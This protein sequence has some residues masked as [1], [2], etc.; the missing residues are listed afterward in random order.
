[1]P[2]ITSSTTLDIGLAEDEIRARTLAWFSNTVH[3]VKVDTPGR[4][5]IDTGSEL[6]LRLWGGLLI[7][8]TS[9][10]TRT[11]VTIRRRPGEQSEV[12]ITSAT[13]TV[14]IKTG[15]KAR[16]KARFDEIVSGVAAALTST[17]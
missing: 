1:V 5:S 2:P 9:L 10:P 12:T 13:R 4:F 8:P 16:Y 17:A 6:K 3:R 15:M 14:G 11:E 7:A